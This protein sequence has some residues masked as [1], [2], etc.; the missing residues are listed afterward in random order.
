M[1]DKNKMAEVLTGYAI[2]KGISDPF[3]MISTNNIYT[4]FVDKVTVYESHLSEY[5]VYYIDKLS[6]R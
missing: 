4:L 3:V 6:L 1:F 5:I 2:S